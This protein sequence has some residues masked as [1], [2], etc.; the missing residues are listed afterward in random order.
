MTPRTGPFWPQEHNLNKLGRAPL[1]DAISRLKFSSS[2]CDLDMQR[3]RNI[4]TIIRKG[5]IGILPVEFGKNPARSL[6]GD[7]L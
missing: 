1:G 4:R 6:G 7:V 5:H 3:T 2:L